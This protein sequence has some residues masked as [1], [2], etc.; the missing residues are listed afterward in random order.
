M[1]ARFEDGVVHPL[2]GTAAMI[3]HMEWAARQHILPYLETGEEGVGAHID[4]RHLKPTPVG[5]TVR[6][7]ST[8]TA[9]TPDRVTSAVEAWNETDKIGEGTFTQALLPVAKLYAP[10]QVA[11]ATPEPASSEEDAPPPAE[12]FNSRRSACLRVEVLRWET[13]LFPCTRY[14]EWL[15]CR[16]QAKTKQEA[17]TVE[18]PFLLRYEIEEWIEALQALQE[19]KRSAYQPEFLESVVVL[20]IESGEPDEF[21][22]D[23]TAKPPDK[24]DFL[25]LRM[26]VTGAALATFAQQLEAQIEGFPSKL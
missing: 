12:L 6:I 19:G 22:V 13:G 17:Q 14:D 21:R 8:V 15:V 16:F 18:G 2:Y 1:Q 23:L 11:L 20:D 10:A 3:S 24:P 4:V 7:R 9:I 26:E 5:A 25:N